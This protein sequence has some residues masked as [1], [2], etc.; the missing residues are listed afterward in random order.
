MFAAQ[1]KESKTKTVHINDIKGKVLQEMLRF[2]YTG[3]VEDLKA[4]A[5]ALIFA[6]EKYDIKELKDL[7]VSSLIKNLSKTNIFDTII[8]ADR[9][10]ENVLLYDCIEFIRHNYQSLFG[11]KGWEKIGFGLM[12]KVMNSIEQVSGEII[13]FNSTL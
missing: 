12:L 6:A 7:C 11:G 10:N 1:M 2:V 4:N 9:C 5:S 3:K 8:I 13:K